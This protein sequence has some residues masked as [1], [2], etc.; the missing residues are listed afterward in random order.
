M[1]R[2]PADFKPDENPWIVFKCDATKLRESIISHGRVESSNR[3]HPVFV[4]PGHH[5]RSLPPHFEDYGDADHHTF[6]KTVEGVAKSSHDTRVSTICKTVERV[7]KSPYNP[8]VNTLLL[9]I[10]EIKKNLVYKMVL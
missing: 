7:A 9:N 10:Y 3:P 8:K 2:D 6:Y 4:K 1:S 5:A